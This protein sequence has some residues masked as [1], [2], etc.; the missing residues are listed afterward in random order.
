MVWCDGRMDS[1]F[2]WTSPHVL[3]SLFSSRHG[4]LTWHPIFLF[5]VFGILPLWKKNRVIALVILYMCAGELF[6]NSAASRWWA[7]DAFGGRR[8]VSLIVWNGLSFA[9]YRLEFV[10]MSEP[11]TIREMTIDR[12]LVPLRLLQRVLR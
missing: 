2:S 9:Q 11:L 12:L 5:A 6:I 8:F 10:S 4:L 1:F 7:D 3:P